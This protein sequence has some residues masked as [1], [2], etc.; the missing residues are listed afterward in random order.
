MAAHENGTLLRRLGRSLGFKSKTERA[1]ELLAFQE[2]ERQKE[3]L[4]KNAPGHS[5]TE[6]EHGGHRYLRP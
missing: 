1:T 3:Q 6:N 5:E 4:G 2:E